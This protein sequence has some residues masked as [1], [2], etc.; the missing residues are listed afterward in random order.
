MQIRGTLDYR[1]AR[2]NNLKGGARRHDRF[3]RLTTDR[4]DCQTTTTTTT[5]A[6]RSHSCLCNISIF[7]KKEYSAGCRAEVG[8]RGKKGKKRK[9][10]LIDL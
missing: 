7:M 1:Q 6:V 8:R 5:N 9:V 10:D 2:L 4:N 3:L